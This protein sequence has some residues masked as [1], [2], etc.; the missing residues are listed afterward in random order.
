MGKAPP[1]VDSERVTPISTPA[2]AADPS[3]RHPG[4]RRMLAVASFTP[5]AKWVVRGLWAA[6][7]AGLAVFTIAAAGG[8]GDPASTGYSVLFIAVVAAPAA[9][10]LLRALLV[11]QSRA[12]WALLGIAILFWAGG[13][14]VDLLVYDGGAIAPYPSAS[15]GLWLVYHG[16]SFAAVLALMRSAVSIVRGSVWVDALVGGLAL[17]ALGAALVAPILADSGVSAG[18][19]WVNLAYPLAD[20]MI[21][22][23]L[24]GVFAMCKGR[25][26][27][28]WALLAVV[29]SL[30]AVVDTLYL[31]GA[32]AGTYTFGT[33]LDAT[34]P[35]MMFL[36][37]L[38]AW[39]EP[40]VTM[41]DGD[42]G[43]SRL[44]LTIGFAVAGL[45]LTT[46]DH[47]HRLS[48]QAV[49]LATLTLVVAFVRTTLTFADLRALAGRSVL[50]KQNKLIL[51]AAGEG[52]IGTDARGAVTF[53]NPAV[54]DMTGYDAGE[55][56]GRTLHE[57]LHHTKSDGTPY[58]IEECPIHASQLDGTVRQS[59]QDVYWHKDGTS[60][61]V[62]YTGTPIVEG[63]RIRGAVVVLRDIS[64]RREVERVKD[65]FTSVVSHELRTPLTSIRGS[66]GLLESGVVGPL[67]DRAQ[68]MVQIAV[69]NT[70]RLVRLIND[71][72]DLERL[73][74]DALRLRDAPCDA[75][76]LIARA[77]DSVLPAAVAADVTLAVDA[78]PG[79]FAADEDRLIQTLTNL[80][81]NAVKFSPAG[82]T[83]LISSERSR[84]EVLDRRA[85]RR[86]DLGG[87]RGQRRQHVLVRHPRRP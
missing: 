62:E 87:E 55:L 67:T 5:V 26:N 13:E 68:R 15:D 6:G 82:G 41:N 73:E 2:D 60:F 86:P 58:P 78:T 31:R 16:L 29:W 49:I 21:L 22:G 53:V 63:G 52:I 75:A 9:L 43:W 44:A 12:T 74:S 23:L 59:E 36:I 76:Q 24:I 45:T 40:T 50:A 79:T 57:A 47:W 56:I 46:V 34:W 42:R 38:A 71:I 83:V 77:T 11:A 1:S 3:V 64:E 66:L 81:S 10:C 32:A 25:P 18:A 65:E 80:I 27:R 37:A 4:A 20:V 85:P 84:H 14:A 51:G 54:T 70:D 33:L 72:L 39:H 7:I 35:A 61:A 28:V 17:A 19:V 48:D 69:Q 30:A 8:P